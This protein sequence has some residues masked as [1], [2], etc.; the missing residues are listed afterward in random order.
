MISGS[1]LIA[2][3]NKRLETLYIESHRWLLNM[4]LAVT[5]DRDSADDL[6]QELYLYLAEKCNPAIFWGNSYNIMYCQQYLKTRWINKQKRNS[7]ILFKEEVYSDEMD[8]PYDTEKD[9]GIQQAFDDVMSELKRLETT[10]M[11]PASRIFSLYWMSDRTLDSVA[12]DI[13]ISKSTTFLAVKKIRQHLKEVINN[14]YIDD[15]NK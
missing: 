5:R 15:G 14:P 11:W 4:A 3:C 10:K 8:I 2:E 9:I 6:V 1:V 12:K 13:K 7:K